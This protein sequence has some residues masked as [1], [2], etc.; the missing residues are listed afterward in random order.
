MVPRREPAE[1]RR[2]GDARE[3][4]RTRPN[5]PELA[6]TRPIFAIITPMRSASSPRVADLLSPQNLMPLVARAGVRLGLTARM[7]ELL[8]ERVML[9]QSTPILDRY[10]PDR[11]DVFV[12]T[13]AKSGTNW[14]MQICVQIAH[15]GAADFDHVHDLVAWPEAPYPEIVALDDPRPRLRSPTKLRVVKTHMPA[16]SVPYVPAAT[17]V[18]IIR[19]PKEVMVSAYYF[20][21]GLLGI[22]D[23]VDPDE[24]FE[25]CRDSKLAPYWAEH[26]AGFW[27]WRERPNVFV[28]TYPELEADLP[29]AVDRLAELMGVELREDERAAVLERA[30]FPWMKAHDGRFAPPRSAFVSREHHPRMMR[31]GKAG[32]S[33]ELLSPEQGEQIDAWSR[34]HLRRLGSDFPYDELFGA[35]TRSG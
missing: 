1:H 31:S 19:D 18:T 5:S 33:R 17:Y 28:R 11:H 7:L 29:G 22:R 30:S 34:E 35:V 21:L 6:R 26:T 3:R 24:F 4:A 10:T 16:R 9:Q 8:M 27:A 2:R 20:A 23:R 32:Q 14:A 13:F 25:I 15:R 12:A